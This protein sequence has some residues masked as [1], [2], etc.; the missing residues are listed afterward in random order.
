MAKFFLKKQLLRFNK[1]QR[2]IKKKK[3]EK[4]IIK[5]TKVRDTKETEEERKES[6]KGVL[7]RKMNA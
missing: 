3:E 5:G 7:G 4:L 1:D 6:I 2:I